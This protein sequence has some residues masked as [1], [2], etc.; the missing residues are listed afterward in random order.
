MQ[1]LFHLL[2]FLNQPYMFRA[3]I[4]PSSGALLRVHTAFG[5]MHRHSADRSHS[6][7]GTQP[8]HRSAAEAVHCNK[9]CIYS[10]KVLM[11]MGEFVAR[12]MLRW[13]KKINKRKICWFLLVAYIVVLVMHGHTNIK[14][15][16]PIIR[17]CKCGWL[18]VQINPDKWSFTLLLVW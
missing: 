17:I 14:L 9:S 10:Q 15:K 13:F 8:W 12:N 4:R 11:G 5:T 7:D 16:N 18:A 1:Q 6:W 3:K 2:I